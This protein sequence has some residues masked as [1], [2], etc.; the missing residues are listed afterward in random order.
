VAD[1]P[2]PPPFIPP[3]TAR[4]PPPAGAS[5]PAPNRTPLLIGIGAIIA[6]LLIGAAGYAYWTGM[7]GDRPGSIAREVTAELKRQG[8]DN[9]MVTMGRDWVA[10]VSGSVVGQDKKQA[11]DAAL[12]GRSEIAGTNFDALELRPS[13][14]EIRDDIA[15]I[16]A[17][18]RLGHITAEVDESG[19]V[20]LNGRAASEH[21][22]EIADD[23]VMG[24]P[25]VS[26]VD[27]RIGLP[28]AVLEREINQALRES[29]FTGV[30]ASVRNIDDISVSGV[31]GGDED[32]TAVIA[33]VVETGSTFREAIDA[34]RVRDEMS[35]AAPPVR[36]E[37]ELEAIAVGA[38]PSIQQAT[39]PA[40]RQSSGP[41][42]AG[43]VEAPP[44]APATIH[45][46]WEGSIDAKWVPSVVARM[47]IQG[48]TA[49]VVAGRT[50]YAERAPYG[51][52]I[53]TCHGT[54][55]F[56]ESSS[57]LFVFSESITKN[58]EPGCPG[59]GL[60]KMSLVSADTVEAQWTRNPEKRP[61]KVEWSGT[62]RK[63]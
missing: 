63:R 56:V 39:P 25:G 45:G 31:L 42:Q 3:A 57:N 5:R 46:T 49:G 61:D 24:V 33:K 62:L 16:L 43:Q 58:L 9:V 53:T 29:G 50:E 18:N 13:Q 44:V 41:V 1:E 34:A 40:A 54:L 55:R 35:V 7:I 32:R 23:V 2:P 15:K 22:I 10:R 6:A 60:V 51:K 20:I 37:R 28:F 27:R 30:R 48:T 26:S 8:F 21:E 17:A 36:V 14:D 47:W 11:L 4:T 19:T 38:A 59:G 52:T 12:V